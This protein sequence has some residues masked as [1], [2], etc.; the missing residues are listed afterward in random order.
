MDQ[1]SSIIAFAKTDT[2]IYTSTDHQMTKSSGLTMIQ[3]NSAHCDLKTAVAPILSTD[4]RHS[5]LDTVASI[6]RLTEV[7]NQRQEDQEDISSWLLRQYITHGT[8]DEVWCINPRHAAV[9][10]VKVFTS[11]LVLR[12][13]TSRIHTQALSSLEMVWM[14]ERTPEKSTILLDQC[15]KHLDQ[16]FHVEHS[17][18]NCLS[19]RT[20]NYVPRT[21]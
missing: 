10:F 14:D 12:M 18:A 20:I 19:Q 17:T 3:S 2:E 16:S 7:L 11:N 1:L 8:T 21:I 9:A 5:A 4:G 15:D 6:F 13:F